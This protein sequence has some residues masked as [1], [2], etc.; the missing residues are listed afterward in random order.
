MSQLDSE[1]TISNSDSVNFTEKSKTK[2]LVKYIDHLKH[3][4][5]EDEP[6]LLVAYI[7]HL[8]MGLL[9]GGQILSKKRQFFGSDDGKVKGTAVTTFEGIQLYIQ[10][11]ILK[12]LFEEKLFC[13]TNFNSKLKNFRIK[14]T[15]KIGE[16]LGPLWLPL[17]SLRF[18]K[19]LC[20]PLGS[21]RSVME[22][23][24]A[25]L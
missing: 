2:A 12:L 10:L 24:G 22:F 17:E 18:F 9:S 25:G 16:S 15:F 13:L 23:L 19:I 3:I 7:Y 21:S 5:E 11:Y 4:A 1:L 8:Y 14:I 20:E 6:L